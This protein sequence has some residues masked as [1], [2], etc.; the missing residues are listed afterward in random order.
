MTPFNQKSKLKATTIIPQQ[1][2]EVP[3]KLL[4]TREVCLCVHHSKKSKISSLKP[5][6]TFHKLL[7]GCPQ[8]VILW[9]ENTTLN[10]FY[11]PSTDL[12]CFFKNWLFF[13]ISVFQIF[14]PQSFGAT[15]GGISETWKLSAF[16]E[17]VYVLHSTK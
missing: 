17:R 12:V 14:P 13:S 11:L 16:A 5:G 2:I 4:Q 1:N 10:W 3:A 6:K 15:T 8:W 7:L 9:N